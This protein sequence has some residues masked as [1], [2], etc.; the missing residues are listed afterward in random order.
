[1]PSNCSGCW[2]WSHNRSAVSWWTPQRWLCVHRD[3]TLAIDQSLHLWN[4]NRTLTICEPFRAICGSWLGASGHM[5]Q[6]AAFLAQGRLEVYAA[7]SLEMMSPNSPNID[8]NQSLDSNTFFLVLPGAPGS[9]HGHPGC[10]SGGTSPPNVSFWAPKTIV[11]VS[12][13]TIMRQK[14]TWKLTSRNQQTTTHFSR[15]KN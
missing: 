1:M 13:I 3:K 12:K 15:E 10:K 6:I 5:Q 4:A 7:T 14:V 11:S 9:S 8:T 2:E